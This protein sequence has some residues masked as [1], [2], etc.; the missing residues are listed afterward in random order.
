VVGKFLAFAVFIVT[1]FAIIGFKAS[2]Y[3][4]LSERG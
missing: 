3:R 2:I 4:Q 1:M